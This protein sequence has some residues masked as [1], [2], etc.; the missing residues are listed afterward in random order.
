MDCVKAAFNWPEFD[1]LCKLTIDKVVPRLLLPLQS[2]GQTIKPCLVH[3]DCWDGNTAMDTDGKAFIFD[4]YSFHGHN[5]YDI[6]DWRPRRHVVS[7]PDYMLKYKEKYRP[8]EPGECPLGTLDNTHIILVDDWD[9]RN[10]LYSLSFNIGNAA[11][12]PKSDQY[13]YQISGM[14]R[15]R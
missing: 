4:V 12:I 2:G 1:I 6:G 3:G 10:R 8:S 15:I 13:P 11:F 5:E 9:D 14:N 7:H